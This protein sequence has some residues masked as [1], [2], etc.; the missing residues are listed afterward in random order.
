M[1]RPSASREV[2]SAPSLSALET[3]GFVTK[4]RSTRIRYSIANSHVANTSCAYLPDS[5]IFESQFLS[6]CYRDTRQVAKDFATF[7]KVFRDD[8]RYRQHE[9]NATIAGTS[10]AWPSLQ[11]LDRYGG[12]TAFRAVFSNSVSGRPS[13][14]HCQ[15]ARCSVKW[16]KERTYL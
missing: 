14:V 7:T 3:K 12:A 5:L 9:D 4:R 16:S 1:F 15:R 8:F 2:R 6:D 10:H 13:T 11:F